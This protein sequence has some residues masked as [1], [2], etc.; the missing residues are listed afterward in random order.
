MVSERYDVIIVGA[1]QGGIACASLL[2]KESNLKILLME[3]S[4]VIGGRYGSYSYKGFTLNN[5]SGLFFPQN[6]FKLL[7]RLDVDIPW[8]EVKMHCYFKVDTG[9]YYYHPMASEVKGIPA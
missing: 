1:G 6:L 3:K 4:S 2:S 5:F 8:S 9:E 7:P